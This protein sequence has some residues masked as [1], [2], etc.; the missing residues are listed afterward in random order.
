M[1]TAPRVYFAMAEDGLFFKSVGRLHQKTRVPILAIIIQGVLAIAIALWGR[2]E[3]I[4]NYV[5]SVDFIFFG[6]TALCIF[7]FRRRG[8][9]ARPLERASPVAGAHNALPNGRATA[10]NYT[11]GITRVPG[12]PVTTAV[13]VAVCWLVVINTVYRYPQNT[14]IGLVILLGGVPAFFFWRWRNSR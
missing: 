5:V 6:A 10:P 14:L 13:F 2:Y 11:K 12:H 1:L 9:V 3:Q 8:A 4:L 7:I